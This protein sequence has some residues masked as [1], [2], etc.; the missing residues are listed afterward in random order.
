MLAHALFYLV[1][2]GLPDRTC[3]HFADVVTELLYFDR[4]MLIHKQ[5]L[6]LLSLCE[7]DLLAALMFPAYLTRDF[8]KSYFTF[9]FEKKIKNNIFLL[10]HG[11]GNS[12]TAAKQHSFDVNFLTYRSR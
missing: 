9:L 11:S 7:I 3:F 4:M 10:V 12:E 8:F 2:C 6:E 1:V 5:L